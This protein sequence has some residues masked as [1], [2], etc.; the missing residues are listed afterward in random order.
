MMDL[1]N[2]PPLVTFAQNL[3]VA[4]HFHRIEDQRIAALHQQADSEDWHGQVFA[5]VEPWE[6]E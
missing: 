1:R 3:A 5:R 2:P 6:G 4:G